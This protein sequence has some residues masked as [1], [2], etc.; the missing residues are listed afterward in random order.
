VISH[1]HQTHE[2]G[3]LFVFKFKPTDGTG[4][5]NPSAELVIDHVVPIVGEFSISVALSKRNTIDLRSPSSPLTMNQPRT[6]LTV[7]INPGHQLIHD[8]YTK[9]ITLLANDLQRLRSVLEECRR[10]KQISDENFDP[11]TVSST[12]A[13]ILPYLSTASPAFSAIP[14]DV[15]LYNSPLHTRLSLASAGFLGDDLADI[16]LI[17]EEWIPQAA[18]IICNKTKVIHD[19]KIRLGTFNV[20][21]NLP[22]QDLGAWVGGSD[23]DAD[24]MLP[25]VKKL[26]E[27]T[28][29]ESN[30]S[31]GEYRHRPSVPCAAEVDTPSRNR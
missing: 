29:C 30:N 24:K 21:G 18:R 1:V 20:N 28:L 4:G 19:L 7:T 11:A 9:Q 8:Q 6:E 26:S 25:L 27:I 16:Q 3:C 13:W 5:T 15:R 10:L 12:H 31:Q 2:Q 14:P 22:T 23:R 17:R